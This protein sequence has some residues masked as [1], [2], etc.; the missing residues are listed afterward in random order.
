MADDKQWQKA[1]DNM[2][3]GDDALPSTKAWQEKARLRIRQR[4]PILIEMAGDIAEGKRKD[5]SSNQ[6]KMIQVLLDR[7]LPTQTDATVE[8]TAPMTDAKA[9]LASLKQAAIANPSLQALLRDALGIQTAQKIESPILN[10]LAKEEPKHS[11]Q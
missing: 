7:V 3:W 6:V 4:V 8:T 5:V 11:I 9:I 10:E 2:K 1:A